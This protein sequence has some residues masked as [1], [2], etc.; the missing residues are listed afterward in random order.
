MKE[1]RTDM[2][3]LKV[4]LQCTNDSAIMSPVSLLGQYTM[5]KVEG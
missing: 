4:Q 3:P 1:V 2:A 5:T